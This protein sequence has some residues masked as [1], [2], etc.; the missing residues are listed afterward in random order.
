M[1]YLKWFHQQNVR[2]ENIFCES[3][4]DCGCALGVFR[5]FADKHATRAICTARCAH[6]TCLE[7]HFLAADAGGFQ[8]NE[9]SHLLGPGMLG[10]EAVA[11]LK[12]NNH[13]ELGG[14]G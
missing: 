4:E 1:Q 7:N 9:G 14:K 11:G 12:D 13:K 10:N 3:S 6:R 8:V 2:I 5:A